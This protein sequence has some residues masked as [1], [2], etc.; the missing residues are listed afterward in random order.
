L[1]SGI[2]GHAIR[3]AIGAGV[4]VGVGLGLGLGAATSLGLGDG[5]AVG[6]VLPSTA[7][8]AAAQIASRIAMRLRTA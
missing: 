2:G 8:A 4:G 6:A 3:V 1:A 5:R 7:H